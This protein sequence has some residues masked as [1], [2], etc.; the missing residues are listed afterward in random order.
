[1][2]GTLKV[3]KGKTKEK[4]QLKGKTRQGTNKREEK[5]GEDRRVVKRGSL[6]IGGR[7][8]GED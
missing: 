4:G 6:Q 8:K 7:T 2:G 3:E 5:R 1:M